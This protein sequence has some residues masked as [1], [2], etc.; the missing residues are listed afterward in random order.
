[1]AKDYLIEVRVKNGYLHGKMREK[2]FQTNVALSEKSGVDPSRISE[3]LNLR[4]YPMS[5]KTGEW[6][7]GVELLAEALDCVPEDLFPAQHLQNPLQKN[8]AEFELN[9]DEFT[10]LAGDDTPETL[11]L[12][13]ETRATVHE[14]LDK[15]ADA[16]PRKAKAVREH[17]FEDATLQEIGDNMTRLNHLQQPDG[18]GVSSS[19]ARS[20]LNVGMRDLKKILAKDFRDRKR[21]GW[22]A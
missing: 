15:L 4:S 1:M 21:H 12:A 11:L 17:F 16:N 14:A 13:D 3:F 22:S 2:G 7:S 18:V 8:K 9:L 10:M 6:L 20:L 5:R 19:R